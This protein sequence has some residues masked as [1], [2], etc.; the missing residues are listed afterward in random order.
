ME[1]R[2][3]KPAKASSSQTVESQLEYSGEVVVE[4]H[5]TPAPGPADLKI[6][7]RRPLPLIPEAPS[8][9]T[10]EDK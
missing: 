1:D 2:K 9:P 7:K 5:A 3:E 6:H 8:P 4:H 10:K